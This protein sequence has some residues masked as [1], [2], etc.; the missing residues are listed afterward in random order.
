MKQKKGV[1]LI[2]SPDKHVHVV[3]KSLFLKEGYVT[4]STYS[5]NHTL[6]KSNPDHYSL[7][8]IDELT[9]GMT[10]IQL[11]LS[12][13]KKLQIPILMFTPNEREDQRLAAF[14]AGAD[15][16]MEKP[17]SYK[18]LVLRTRAILKRTSAQ[19]LKGVSRTV[20]RTIQLKRIVINPSAHRVVVD[21]RSIHFSLKEFDLLYY[22]VLNADIAHTR[23]QLLD[24][25]WRQADVYDHRTVDTHIKRIRDKL[26]AISPEVGA[27]ITTVRG[28]GYSFRECPTGVVEVE[29]GG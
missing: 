29:L 13:R 17:L 2:V 27:M 7:I 15:D 6:F 20:Y 5:P 1:I 22:L 26:S 25:V 14:E 19:I 28:I 10:N 21:D 11:C 24:A 9:G 12:I 16:C 3:L 23:S 8:I 4:E 18:E